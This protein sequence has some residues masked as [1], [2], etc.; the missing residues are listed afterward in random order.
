MKIEN[1]LTRI[2]TYNAGKENSKYSC[3]ILN[4]VLIRASYNNETNKDVDRV[5]SELNGKLKNL[6]KSAIVNSSSNPHFCY[7][8]LIAT[9]NES[10][11][12]VASTQY[13]GCE[14]SWEQKC[15]ILGVS[16]EII[17]EQKPNH[18]IALDPKELIEK[19]QST[20]KDYGLDNNRLAEIVLAMHA[21]PAIERIDVMP[22]DENVRITQK[23]IEAV[24]H[25]DIYDFDNDE[26]IVI[27]SND[28]Y[29]DTIT[30]IFEKSDKVLMFRDNFT[31]HS[32]PLVEMSTKLFF[33]Y[34][35]TLPN[36]LLFSEKQTPA[37]VMFKQYLKL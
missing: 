21:H 31:K 33:E 10:P 2:S 20:K 27:F 26:C 24:I 23:D 22:Y 18:S 36:P 4:G 28:T 12:L 34:L 13:F 15:D 29:L 7:D 32:K 1:Y 17:A 14:I 19:L 16:S 3:V 9:L 6:K 37:T 8:E 35:S 11:D 25:K 5:F 30:F